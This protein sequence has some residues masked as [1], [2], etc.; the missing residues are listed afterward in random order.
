MINETEKTKTIKTKDFNLIFNKETGE[1]VTWGRTLEEDPEF[2]PVGPIIADI[3]ISTICNLNCPACYKDNTSKGTNMSF[4]TFKDIFH[5]LPRSLTQIAFGIADINCCPDL[6]KIFKYCKENDYQY[7]TPN[8]T[9]NGMGMSSYWYDFL[10]NTCGA[11]AVSNHIEDL[12]FNAIKELTSRGMKQ[13]NIHQIICDESFEICMDLIDKVKTDPRLEKL[14]A[15][16]F[17]HLKNKGRGLNLHTISDEHYKLFMDKLFA[18]G[19]NFGCD[20]CGASK[21]LQY[22]VSD[23]IKQYITPCESGRESMYCNVEGIFFPCSFTE[24][25]EEW[26][27][28]IDLKKIDNFLEDVWFNTKVKEWRKNLIANCFNCPKYKI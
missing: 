12:C 7:I 22:G 20:A 5:K 26:S 4:E 27:E 1:T 19:I 23:K 2:S 14:N 6:T 11:V 13:V 10:S 9:I 8:V 21:L 17:L 16:V 3:E 25:C 18:S 15:V 28:G 24:D